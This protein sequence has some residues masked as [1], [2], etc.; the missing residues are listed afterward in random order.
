MF[1]TSPVGRFTSH[2]KARHASLKREM[3]DPFDGL[4]KYG[5][6]TGNNQDENTLAKKR[7]RYPSCEEHDALKLEVDRLKMKLI[8]KEG[9]YME[10]LAS[11]KKSEAFVKKM[12]LTVKQERMEMESTIERAKREARQSGQGSCLKG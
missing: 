2:A 5:I 12:E 1:E 10:A 3:I 9:E 8:E 11:A 6:N 7:K 4:E